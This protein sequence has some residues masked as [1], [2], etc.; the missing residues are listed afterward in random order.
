MVLT[1]AGVGALASVAFREN[2]AGTTSYDRESDRAPAFP[3]AT[4]RP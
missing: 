2:M 1:D 3:N 4:E